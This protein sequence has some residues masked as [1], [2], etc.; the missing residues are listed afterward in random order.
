MSNDCSICTFL[1]TS[2]SIPLFYFKF[3][4]STS[5]F[6][7]HFLQHNLWSTLREKCPNTEFFLVCLFRFL[8]WILRFKEYLI[9]FSSKDF[10]VNLT[11]SSVS[12]LIWSHLLKKSWMKNFIFYVIIKLTYQKFS[13]KLLT[14]LLCTSIKPVWLATVCRWRVM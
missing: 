1:R 3:D 12:P 11:I 6:N 13:E 5:Q 4:S 10:L 8:N 7:L 14:L 9:K 2:L